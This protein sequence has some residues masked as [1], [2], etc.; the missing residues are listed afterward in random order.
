[1]KKFFA[2]VC[3]L[4]LSLS[5]CACYPRVPGDASWAKVTL[6]E[7]SRFS[8]E[9][10]NA[11]VDCVKEALKGYEGCTM[12]ALW[13]DEAKSDEEM[14]SPQKNSVVLFSNLKI[15]EGDWDN[16]FEAGTVQEGWKWN[17]VRDSEDDP[18]RVYNE[19]FC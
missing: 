3:A 13:Y 17:L 11:A 14:G 19:G 16:G 10:L 9:E 5:L 6:G 15:D 18:W 12:T 1:M 4:A 8:K 2:L 7:S